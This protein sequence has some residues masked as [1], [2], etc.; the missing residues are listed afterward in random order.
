MKLNHKRLSMVVGA[1]LLG[2]SVY[3]F[4]IMGTAM[5]YLTFVSVGIGIVID[6]TLILILAL[7][8]TV[9]Y[10]HFRG[11]KREGNPFS[12]PAYYVAVM[13]VVIAAIVFGEIGKIKSTPGTYASMYLVENVVGLDLHEEGE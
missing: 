1:G 4:G 3:Y 10:Y 9:P 7:L 2:V 8:L 5:V 12:K 13:L 11:M 6:I